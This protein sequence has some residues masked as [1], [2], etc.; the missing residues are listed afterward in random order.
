MILAITRKTR[1][2]EQWCDVPEYIYIR[3]R[4]TLRIF[5]TNIRADRRQKN[6]FKKK[7]AIIHR[8]I[9]SRPFWAESIKQFEQQPDNLTVEKKTPKP[10]QISF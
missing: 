4:E 8:K 6:R 1:F 2:F 7:T 10:I 3:S 9:E 5:W